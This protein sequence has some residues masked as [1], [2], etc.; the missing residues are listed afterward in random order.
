MPCLLV[1]FYTELCVGLNWSIKPVYG[2]E[3]ERH[4]ERSTLILRANF[5]SSDFRIRFLQASIR[6]VTSA[7][8]IRSI[9]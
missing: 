4:R 9:S 1:L 6:R 2:K 7:Q 3:I 8:W 5:N